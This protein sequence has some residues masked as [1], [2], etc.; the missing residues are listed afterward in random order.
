[1][2]Q[3]MALEVMQLMQ[4][5]IQQLLILLVMMIMKKPMLENHLK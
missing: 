1:M 4:V 2:K 5:N 3:R